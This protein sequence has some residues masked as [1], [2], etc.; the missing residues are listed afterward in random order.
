MTADVT[1]PSCLEAC[2]YRLG[3]RTAGV[4]IPLWWCNCGGVKEFPLSLD[5]F[6]CYLRI[7]AFTDFT[8]PIKHAPCSRRRRRLWSRASVAFLNG[9]LSPA[10]GRYWTSYAGSWLWI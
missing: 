10:P 2:L 1:S 8:S 5:F 3:P 7:S 9:R 4:C 6:C